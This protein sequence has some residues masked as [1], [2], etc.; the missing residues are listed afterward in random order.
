MIKLKMQYKYFLNF[1]IMY[2]LTAHFVKGWCYYFYISFLPYTFDGIIFKQK[3]I[4]NL[5]SVDH[6]QCLFNRVR[7]SFILLR[8]IVFLI[9]KYVYL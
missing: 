3:C 6:L 2:S 7:I 8:K 9:K 5:L 4:K 1:N